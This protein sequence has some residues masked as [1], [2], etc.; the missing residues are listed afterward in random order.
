MVSQ[1]TR[2]RQFEFSGLP[3]TQYN[4]A[5]SRHP[6]QSFFLVLSQGLA[7]SHFK[8]TSIISAYA[9]TVT[10]FKNDVELPVRN[11][12]KLEDALN[13][14]DCGSMDADET[15]RIQPVSQ[16]V[17]RCAIEH[18][19][20]SD[21]EV[22]IDAGTLDPI[23]L[24]HANEAGCSCRSDDKP[25]EAPVYSR[26]CGDHAQNATAKLIHA[27]FLEPGLGAGQRRFKSLVAEGFE[28]IVDR[29]GFEGANGVPF[30]SVVDATLY[31]MVPLRKVSPFSNAAPD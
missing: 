5:Y 30:V 12:L 21:V 26:P 20:P 28:Q 8:L 13:V 4:L 11:G 7:K 22:G 9:R 27:S 3:A 1:S 2:N 31:S 29:I 15:Q 24:R 14:D 25:V 23:N 17:Q 19:L 10:V 6:G 18:L 16:V